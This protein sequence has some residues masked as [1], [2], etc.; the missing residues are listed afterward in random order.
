MLE[1]VDSG[2]TSN[3]NDTRRCRWRATRGWRRWKRDPRP[4]RRELAGIGLERHGGE[5]E[6]RA[7][8]VVRVERDIALGSVRGILMRMHV[9]MR[10]GVRM[11]VLDRR[12]RSVGVIVPVI[13]VVEKRKDVEPEEPA[14]GGCRG[15][16]AGTSPAH[17]RHWVCMIL[18]G[19]GWMGP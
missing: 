6:D 14:Y 15:P 19:R 11:R 17:V 7:D 8:P 10:V 1:E 9:G 4:R 16:D 12:A 18:Q 3:E 2:R 5:M 13:D